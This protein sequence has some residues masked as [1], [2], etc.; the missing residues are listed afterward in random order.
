M[1]SPG[2]HRWRTAVLMTNNLKLEKQN[3]EM[4]DIYEIIMGAAGIRK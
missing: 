1:M 2:G 4:T 3:Y